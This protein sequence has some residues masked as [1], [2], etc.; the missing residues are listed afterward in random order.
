MEE[1]RKQWLPQAL[2]GGCVGVAL[3]GA[4]H[5]V[6]APEG[7]LVAPKV[8]TADNVPNHHQ[9][10]HADQAAHDDADDPGFFHFIHSVSLL[11]RS[12]A[13]LIFFT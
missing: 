11:Y 8:D 7:G 2:I 1:I 12:S 6:K 10:H 13:C 3:H 5:E 9:H 4:V